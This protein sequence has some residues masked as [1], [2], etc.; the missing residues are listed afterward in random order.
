MAMNDKQLEFCR[1]VVQGHDRG[2]AYAMAYGKAYSASCQVCASRLLDREDVRAEIA[3]LRGMLDAEAVM[4]LE[5]KRK[6]LKRM[7]ECKPD[8]VDGG[9]ELV[10]EVLVDKEGVERVKLPDKLRAIDLDSK[11]AGHYAAERVEV[12]GLSEI[13]AILAGVVDEPLVR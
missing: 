8:E 11:L 1:L 10:Q 4:S 5:Y 2:R 9:S 7:V 12:E 6:L 13:A 3:R